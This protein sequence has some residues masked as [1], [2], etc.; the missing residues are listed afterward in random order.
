M[1]QRINRDELHDEGDP[2]D[3]RFF[4]ATD[5]PTAAAEVA[6]AFD[7]GERWRDPG[8]CRVDPGASGRGFDSRE[9]A[10]ARAVPRCHGGGVHAWTLS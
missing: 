4:I 7:P 9:R 6:A 3:L 1:L 8:Q 2:P 10:A 5:D